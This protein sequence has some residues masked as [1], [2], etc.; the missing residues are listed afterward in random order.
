MNHAIITRVS[1]VIE[2]IRHAVRDDHG[3]ILYRRLQEL[4]VESRRA[5][6]MR[7][8]TAAPGDSDHGRTIGTE[9]ERSMT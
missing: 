8:G 4:A 6:I 9:H 3:A 2:T 5:G 7:A 1:S